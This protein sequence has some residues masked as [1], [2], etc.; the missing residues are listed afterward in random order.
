MYLILAANIHPIRVLH[1]VPCGFAG[2]G[3]ENGIVNVTNR[4]SE[5]RFRVSICALDSLETFSKRIERSDSEYYLMPKHGG[6]IDWQ[7]IWPLSRVIRQSGAEIVHSH[8]WGTFLYSVLAAK[9]AGVL[10]IHGEHG[11]NEAVLQS[12]SRA[13][14]WVKSR[15]GR[16]L[17][18]LVTVSQAL[19][20]E[21]KG[22]GVSPERI[23]WIPNGVDTDRFRP[24]TDRSEMRRRF[25]LPE[26]GL[27][28]GSIGR[29][30]ALKNHEVLIDA[31]ALLAVRMP[32]L[33][34]GIM[35][36]G[37]SEKRLRERA[38][39]SAYSSR[40]FFLGH[41]SDPQNFYAA[42]DIFALP[43]KYEGMS[44]VVLEAMAGG[45]PVVCADLP[46]HREVFNADSEGI[47][48]APCTP[49]NLADALG[50]L[51]QDSA[52]RKALGSAARDKA[53]SQFSMTQMVSGYEKLYSG[54][55]SSHLMDN[56][57][58]IQDGSR[59]A[60]HPE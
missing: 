50:S 22:Y 27:L 57:Q 30:D 2:G 5:D 18:R 41:Q 59:T 54:L 28:I 29:L 14:R 4:L 21:W 25:G 10:I 46:A 45:L 51:C 44:N 17:D 49:F 60:L 11:K 23:R 13:R 34:L 20:M 38:E 52:R 37:P 19:A 31:F 8:N 15:L 32:E 7:L 42:M 48:V 24:R 3:M 6:G 56:Q 39:K 9:L 58:R 40:I 43:S 33:Y 55:R 35:G 1:V 36:T 16:R 47:V 26:E 53:L 12:D